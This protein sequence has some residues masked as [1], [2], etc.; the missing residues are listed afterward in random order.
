VIEGAIVINKIVRIKSCARYF[1]YHWLQKPGVTSAHGSRMVYRQWLYRTQVTFKAYTRSLVSFLFLATC[2]LTRLFLFL[3]IIIIVFLLLCHSLKFV[4][5]GKDSGCAC[6]CWST[7]TFHSTIHLASL[8]YAT[9]VIVLHGPDAD[10]CSDPD[11][12]W[13]VRAAILPARWYIREVN[14]AQ[15]ITKRDG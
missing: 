14:S 10:C 2:Q 9:T 6:C 8:V 3:H 13:E 11:E 7:A 12:C 5:S 1:L 15:A 4:Y